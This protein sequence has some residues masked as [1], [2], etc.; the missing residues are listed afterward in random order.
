MRRI[1][2]ALAVLASLV[3]AITTGA[4]AAGSGSDLKVT[5]SAHAAGGKLRGGFTVKNEGAKT[6]PVLNA[7]VKILGPKSHGKVPKL[8]VAH[9][10]VPALDPGAKKHLPIKANLPDGLAKGHWSVVACAGSC[11]GIGGFTSTGSTGPN[12]K[13]AT[14]PNAPTPPATP[15]PTPTPACTPF[16]GPY[17]VDQAIP[18]VGAHGGEY[19]AFVPPS[20]N[21]NCAMPLLVWMHG[22]G[23]TAKEDASNVGSFAA[24]TG[25][26]YLTLSLGGRDGACWEPKPDEAKVTMALEDFETH[27]NVDRHRVFLGGYSSGGDLAYRTGFR[28][29]STFAGLLI[30]NSA[31]VHDTE[32]TSTESLAAATTKFHIAHLA[33]TEDGSYQ[34][35]HVRMEIEEVEKAGFPVTFIQK[36]GTH[37]DSH[38]VPDL[39]ENLLPL[40]ETSGWT[41]P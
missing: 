37:S 6:S 25:H 3:L 30:E 29:S 31:P 11:A 20:Y 16:A 12:Q 34:I 2:F 18:F 23:A 24:E 35:N 7:T 28:H 15:T 22:C 17:P 26:G 8:T 4:L 33:H 9:D 39:K 1:V 27:F 32:S 36:T 14:A 38:T 21:P 10:K 19:T 13:K 40:I 5:G 41:S